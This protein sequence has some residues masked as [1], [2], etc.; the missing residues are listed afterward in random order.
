M[1]VLFVCLLGMPVYAQSGFT[2][3]AGAELNLLTLE[4]QKAALGGVT[5]FEIRM[6]PVFAM[7]V[8]IGAGYGWNDFI[9][10]E[11][12]MF[13]RWYFARLQD[14]DFFVQTE[15]GLLAAFLAFDMS[16]SRGSPSIGLMLGSRLHLSPAWYLEPYIRGGY[17]YLGG[18]GIIAG[19]F[20]PPGSGVSPKHLPGR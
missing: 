6:G 5:I 8:N 16:E 1:M 9:S 19:R 17:P 13:A 7:G 10:I 18:V 12:R 20:L 3:G 15:A 14:V 4:E 2:I 11:N